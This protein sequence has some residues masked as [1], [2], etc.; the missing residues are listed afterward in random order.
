MKYCSGNWRSRYFHTPV[1]IVSMLAMSMVV[2]FL[3][4]PRWSIARAWRR[5]A[6][7]CRRWTDRWRK[8]N[9]T[10]SNSFTVYNGWRVVNRLTVMDLRESY[11][12]FRNRYGKSHGQKW[13]QNQDEELHFGPNPIKVHNLFL[14]IYNNNVVSVCNTYEVIFPTSKQSS[15]FQKFW[16]L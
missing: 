11:F 2:N 8:S 15:L 5:N 7:T 1:S 6:N 12:S 3:F 9:L 13:G 16:V 10:F 14:E 4:S